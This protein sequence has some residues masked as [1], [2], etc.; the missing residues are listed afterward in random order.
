MSRSRPRPIVRAVR[1]VC[2]EHVTGAAYK[3]P[4]QPAY[5]KVLPSDNPPLVRLWGWCSH[6]PC[7][8]A[9]EWRELVEVADAR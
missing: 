1:W 5:E 8:N 4:P 9:G 2:D 3:L 7:R 6:Y